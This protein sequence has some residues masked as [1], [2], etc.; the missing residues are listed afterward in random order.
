MNI[1]TRLRDP[2][3]VIAVIAVTTLGLSFS[4]HMTINVWSMN[5][6]FTR[7]ADIQVDDLKSPSDTPKFDATCPVSESRGGSR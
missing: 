4:I 2:L 6:G 5:S 1:H 7:F 3:L